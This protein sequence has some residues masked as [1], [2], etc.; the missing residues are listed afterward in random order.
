MWR[1]KES[2]SLE[3]DMDT[4]NPVVFVNAELLRLYV[5]RR[6]RALIQV[7]RTEGGTVIGN[8]TDGKELVVKGTPPVPLTKFVEVI[9][10]A[11]SDKSIHAEI[12]NNFG[13][14]IDTSSY[15]QLCQL[16]NGEY[17]QLFI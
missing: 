10:I 5:G 7:V 3:N 11:D 15:N 17:K 4:S 8:S 16:A 6:V 9:G 2:L 14:T 13:E 12:W 1:C